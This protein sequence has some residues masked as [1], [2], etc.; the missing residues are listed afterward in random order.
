M[1]YFI[2]NVTVNPASHS[3]PMETS[4]CFIFGQICACLDVLFNIGKY[5]PDSID[6]MMIFPLGIFL[7]IIFVVGCTLF[8]WSDTDMTFPVHHESATT[9]S[10]SFVSCVFLLFALEQD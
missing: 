7:L 9:R 4:E 5:N 2:L 6:D 8:R 1:T 3:A 10:S